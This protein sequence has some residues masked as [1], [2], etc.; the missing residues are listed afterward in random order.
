[1]SDIVSCRSCGA[2]IIWAFTKDGKRMPVD[3]L[4]R[5]GGNLNLIEKGPIW[6]VELV[7]PSDELAYESHFATCV[8]ANEWRS[9]P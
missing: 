6:Q 2:R 7:T 9:R 5:P 3:A 8:D 4:P 1:M